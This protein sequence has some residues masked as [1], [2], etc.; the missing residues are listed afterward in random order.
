VQEKTRLALNRSLAEMAIIFLVEEIANL[1]FKTGQT[2]FDSLAIAVVSAGA[3]Y[4][5]VHHDW[6]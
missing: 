6:K 1:A 3:L 2:V 5:L 4:L